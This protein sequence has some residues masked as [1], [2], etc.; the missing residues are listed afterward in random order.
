MNE[1]SRAC[2]SRS[3][4]SNSLYLVDKITDLW[5]NIGVGGSSVHTGHFTDTISDNLDAV[6]GRAGELLAV[7]C[8]C[9]SARQASAM[10][11]GKGGP[12]Q[13]DRLHTPLW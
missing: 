10:V 5:Y 2:R 4:L 7:T 11:L 6:C 13:C 1:R 9:D 3:W 8:E 12:M